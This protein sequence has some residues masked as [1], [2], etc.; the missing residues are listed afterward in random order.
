MPHP[1]LADGGKMGALM[2]GFDWLTTLFG[3]PATWPQSLRST[4]SAC[5]NTPAVS[6]LYWGPEFRLLYNDAYAP[7]LQDRHPWALGRPMPEVWPEVWQVLGPQAEAV[8]QTGQGFVAEDQRLVFEEHSG[9]RETF[10]SYNF[11]PI[12]GEDGAVAGILLT[13][14]DTTAKTLSDRRLAAERERLMGLFDQ[15]HGFMA[16]LRSPN[17]VFELTNPSYMQLIGHRDVIGKPV[18]EALPEVEGQ[19]FFELLD[20]VYAS[21]K[22]FRGKAMRV[23]LQRMP[24][25]PTEERFVDLVYQP[26]TDATGGVTGIFVE[27]TDVTEMKV[28][29]DD[30]REREQRLRLI[31]EA[32]T[33][34]AILTLDAERVVTTWP[35]GAA[36]IF[37]YTAEEIIGQSADVLFT[38]EDRAAG[39]PAK[40]IVGARADGHAPD[41]RWH[42]RKDGS[43]VFLNGTMR[44]LRDAGGQEIGFLKVA[45]DETE[46]RRVE[47]EIRETEERY[48]L[49]A[50][51][52]NDAI[53]D[54]NLV[55][56]HIRWNEAVGTLFGYAPDEV[57]PTGA[58]W[59]A[60]IH[61]ED[62]QRVVTGITAT[63]GGETD[64]WVAEYRFERRDGT[65]A[66]IL[67][68]GTVL[69]DRNGQAVRMVGAMH[70]LTRHKQ[71]EV[72]LRQLNETLEH[73]VAQEVAS[74]LKTEETLR[75]SQKLEAIGQLTGGVAHDFNN[76]LT[77]IKSSTDLLKRPGLPEERRARY[78]GAISDTVD[79]A[80]RLT[81]Q[82]LA[83]ARR[84]ALK[85][86]VFDIGQSVR[87]IGD[88]VGTLTGA[89][90]QVITRLP[91][92]PCFVNADPSQFDTA[93]VNLAV[94][95][96]D[97][98]DG[99]GQLTVS[100]WAVQEIP[101][102][103]KHKAVQGQ[104]VAVSVADTGTGIPPEQIERI[105]EPFFT[106]KGV[107]Q[108]TGLGLS[109]VFGFT[110]QSD[111]EVRV[112]STLGAGTTFTLYLPQV[113]TKTLALEVD[114]PELLMDGHGTCVL[115]VED[116]RE[117]GS[118]ATQ[119]LA[120]LG[121]RT[122]WAI[123]AEEAL[124]ELDK[125]AGRFDVVFTDVVMPGM[126]GVDLAQEIR[127]RHD[128]LPVVLT[129]G[130]SHVLA[131]NGTHGFELLHK[132]YSVEQLSR[133][134]RKAVSWQ[135]RR[136]GLNR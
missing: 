43:R 61:P 82:L 1:F 58:W 104:F 109:Q 114:E 41:V 18:R 124:V 56:G 129:S 123:N 119:T 63:I 5:L 121:Y 28:A 13:A 79:R 39:Q 45:R 42:L 32:A 11:A 19:G 87:T 103:R 117:V 98:M 108:G 135:R 136:R 37:G 14:M 100:V 16:M 4:L 126:N 8:M 92:V 57:E 29:S 64:S 38:L 131:Q 69:R 2:R 74:R 53:W 70:D 26:V 50:R 91:D 46:R 36:D 24:G 133:V 116:N 10:W 81:G 35:A 90:I 97:A 22:P 106:T 113:A 48:R 78:I 86:E 94:N 112:E 83:F 72:M 25:A 49:A 128:D 55:T 120:E 68:R 51:A 7:A 80:A 52:T 17:H 107:G 15:A 99:A 95:A 71:A 21:G 73:R 85:P 47:E 23:G 66:D 54:W 27:G 134:L 122:V 33:D 127:K 9:P 67:D 96:R 130:Y 102:V 62:R 105:F 44:V 3:D 30:L 89:R 101:A 93:L 84:Q 59:K 20:H 88:M 6:A 110:K 111:G 132:P 77:V 40:E 75:Q 12:R 115:M 60:T 76:L 118:F 34:Y 125:D 31:V 65:Y